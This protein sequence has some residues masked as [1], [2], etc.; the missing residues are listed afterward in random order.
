MAAENEEEAMEQEING[1]SDGDKEEHDM[2]DGATDSSSDGESE[3]P[4]IKELQA[5]VC[6]ILGLTMS[7][8]TLILGRAE[9]PQ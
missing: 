6:Y 7:L 3:D 5:L 2:E 8:L 1:N 4:Q 9:S